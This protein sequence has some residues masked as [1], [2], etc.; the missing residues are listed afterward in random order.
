LTH[1]WKKGERH[2]RHKHK[3][4][5]WNGYIEIYYPNHPNASQRGY[6][7]EHRLIMERILCRYLEKK[8]D[9][10][11]INGIKND[12]R[13]ENLELLSHS[14]HTRINNPVMFRWSRSGGGA[15]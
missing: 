1:R 12:N 6:I 4:K 7:L 5:K 3:N 14:E 15:Q 10:H 9:V 2:L 13:I 11:H 8:E